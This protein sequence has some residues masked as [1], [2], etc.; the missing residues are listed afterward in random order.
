M[1]SS[2]L[3]QMV[4]GSGLVQMIPVGPNIKHFG[5]FGTFFSFLFFSKEG[6]ICSFLPFYIGDAVKN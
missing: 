4:F 2:L 1:G 6:C 3:A 5:L